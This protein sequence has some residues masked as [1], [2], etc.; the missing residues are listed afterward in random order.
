M[1]ELPNRIGHA[2][3]AAPGGINSAKSFLASEA[4]KRELLR[5]EIVIEHRPT[6]E[7]FWSLK[8]D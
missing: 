8:S 2:A 1:K 3:Q 4:L 7:L 5:T 6:S